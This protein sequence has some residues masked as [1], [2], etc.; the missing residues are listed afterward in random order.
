MHFSCSFRYELAAPL[1]FP[2]PSSVIVCISSH[3]L[4]RLYVSSEVFLCL[5]VN[6]QAAS[7]AT[8]VSRSLQPAL[9][10]AEESQKKTPHSPTNTLSLKRNGA[11]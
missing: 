7:L 2:N 9:H 10:Q 6:V 3:L 1:M 8:K 5:S 4:L 11:V